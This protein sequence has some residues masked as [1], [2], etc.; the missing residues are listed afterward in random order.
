MTIIYYAECP[1]ECVYL[2]NLNKYTS[3][4][5]LIVYFRVT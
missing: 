3:I 4:E 1:K 2:N 5:E